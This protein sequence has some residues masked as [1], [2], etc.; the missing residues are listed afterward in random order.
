VID[1]RVVSLVD[2]A[3]SL[4]ALV[5]ATVPGELDGVDLF[6]QDVD[7]DRAVYAEALA[8][9]FDNGWA[10]LYAL[11][12]LTTKYIDA[13]RPE[14]YGLASDPGEQNNLFREGS[15]NPLAARL[16][17]MK[18]RWPALDVTKSALPA[19]DDETRSRLAALGYASGSTPNRQGR[20]PDPKDMLPVYDRTLEAEAMMRA[21]RYAEA[22][23]RLGEAIRTHADSRE[24]LHRLGEAYALANRLEDAERTLR[25]CLAL[26][27]SPPAGT[28]LAQVL[29]RQK[30][31]DEAEKLLDEVVATDPGFGA[32]YVARGDLRAFEGRFDEARR[33]YEQAITVDPYR[34]PGVVRARMAE[35][36]AGIRAPAS[37]SAAGSRPR[38]GPP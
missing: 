20:L 29:T 27:T 9:H 30:R 31:Y 15:G 19:V 25:R 6:D 22:I 38:A 4:L 8:G 14:H 7:R 26:G 10:P 2:L 28:L 1:D 13:P 12:T 16:D 36:A 3:P 24:T 33:L 11:R 21:G 35:V 32:A 18:R 34:T 37:R 17:D 23:E 5:G